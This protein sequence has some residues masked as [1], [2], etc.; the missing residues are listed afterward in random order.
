MANLDIRLPLSSYYMRITWNG[1]AFLHSKIT[2]SRLIH[3]SSGRPPQQYMNQDEGAQCM[4][5]CTVVSYTVDYC[6]IFALLHR[7]IKINDIRVTR[8][9]YPIYFRRCEA[10][11]RRGRE[12]F[13]THFC[14][15]SSED[16]CL[17]E[18]TNDEGVK[19]QTFFSLAQLLLLFSLDI[20]PYF[21][22]VSCSWSICD[23]RYTI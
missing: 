3:H 13:D 11:S 10:H 19:S 1:P 8:T 7:L 18:A 15:I 5:T 6:I 12:T 23:M 4:Y 9:A 21:F 20:F 2:H 14:G 17:V 16:A 22:F